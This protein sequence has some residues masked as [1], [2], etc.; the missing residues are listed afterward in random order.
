V[1]CG[2]DRVSE[3]GT[4]RV[5]IRSGGCVTEP[6]RGSFPTATDLDRIESSWRMSSYFQRLRHSRRCRRCG[7]WLAVDQ[8]SL[9]T[10]S[11]CQVAAGR[12]GD[13]I[14]IRTKEAAP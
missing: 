12:N 8:P 14:A 5:P 1:L 4:K 7:A 11:P 10:C 9:D 13:R 3:A 6:I 2:T